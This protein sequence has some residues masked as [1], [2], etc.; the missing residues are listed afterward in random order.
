VSYD[1]G[2]GQRLLLQVCKISYTN[3]NR[4]ITSNY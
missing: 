2:N 4:I 3:K 1:V